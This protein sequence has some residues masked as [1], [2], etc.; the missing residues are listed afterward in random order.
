VLILF[1]PD[2]LI[3][4]LNLKS[5]TNCQDQWK[6]ATNLEMLCIWNSEFL[7]SS[8]NMDEDQGKNNMPSDIDQQVWRYFIFYFKNIKK[9]FFLNFLF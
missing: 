3:Q 7:L 9:Y 8:Q 5:T 2:L 6:S 4:N 1:R